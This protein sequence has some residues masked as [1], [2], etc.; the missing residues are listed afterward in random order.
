MNKMRPLSSI[1]FL[2][3]A[4]LLRQPVL[5][6]VPALEI[7]APE[8][9]S[10]AA[11]ELRTLSREELGDLLEW[12]GDASGDGTPV[13]IILVDEESVAARSA[14]PWV[15]GYALPHRNLVVLLPGRVPAYPHGSL[16]ALL[17]HELT[18]ILVHRASGG[19]PLPR[20]FEEGVATVAARPW[21]VSDSGRLIVGSWRHPAGT[22]RDLDRAFSGTPA[23][24]RSAYALSAY[25][26]Q[27]LV[28]RQGHQVVPHILEEVAA[29]QEFPGAF[30]QASGGSVALFERMV[31]RRHRFLYHWLPFLTSSGTLWMAITALVVLAV[32]R[33]R[34]Q[35]AR[36]KLLW[37]LEDEALSGGPPDVN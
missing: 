2:L 27:E 16:V 20:W 33:K 5:A 4:G 32:L 17:R 36:R 14:P 7:R 10:G 26:V 9:L 12:T 19:F 21:S 29:G 35:S 13:V 1:L 24:V 28:R 30:R 31:L 37:E 6:E 18:H 11:T 15:S 3:L 23:Q 25:A 8:S 22:F 34:Q